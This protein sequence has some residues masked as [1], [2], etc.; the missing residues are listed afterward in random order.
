MNTTAPT[1]DPRKLLDQLQMLT[2]AGRY[3]FLRK[4]ASAKLLTTVRQTP[5][6]R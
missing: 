3:A 6:S 5:L 4:T 2:A 1:P